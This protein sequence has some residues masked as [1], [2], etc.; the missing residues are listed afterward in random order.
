MIYPFTA[1]L[2]TIYVSLQLSVKAHRN[3]YGQQN[4]KE[5]TKEL[6]EQEKQLTV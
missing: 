2:T 4:I 6:I 1:P 5:Q 3:I